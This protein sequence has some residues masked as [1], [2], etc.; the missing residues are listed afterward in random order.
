M[1]RI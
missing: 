1:H